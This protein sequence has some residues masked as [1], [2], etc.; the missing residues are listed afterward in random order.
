MDVISRFRNKNTNERAIECLL[1]CEEILEEIFH[2]FQDEG[3]N[4]LTNIE[5]KLSEFR[6]MRLSLD[7]EED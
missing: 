3:I 4:P 2:D 5:Q 7:R 6:S 1:F